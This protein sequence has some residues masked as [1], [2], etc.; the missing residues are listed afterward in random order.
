M[1]E[2][3]P[4]SSSHMLYRVLLQLC[5][6][7]CRSYAASA[8][9]RYSSHRGWC[10]IWCVPSDVMQV[11]SILDTAAMSWPGLQLAVDDLEFL[12]G[13]STSAAS[14]LEQDHSGMSL[15]LKES[16]SEVATL[17]ETLALQRQGKDEL[18]QHVEMLEGELRKEAT[19]RAAASREAQQQKQVWSALEHLRSVSWHYEHY[20]GAI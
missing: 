11:L 8:L 12:V 2:S 13:T 9:M 14:R 17:K 15:A 5:G 16:R 4:P 1:S 7:S 3:T 18:R 6:S 20:V 10:S 19:A